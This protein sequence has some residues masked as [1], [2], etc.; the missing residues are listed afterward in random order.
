M[1]VDPYKEGRRPILRTPPKEDLLRIFRYG[2][3][4]FKIMIVDLCK[5]FVDVSQLKLRRKRMTKLIRIN[6]SMKRNRKKK[7][8]NLMTI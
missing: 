4:Q 8:N 3:I 2:M 1:E 7:L 6:K 5:C